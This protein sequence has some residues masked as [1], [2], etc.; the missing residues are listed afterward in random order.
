MART[1]RIKNKRKSGTKRR[2]NYN[3]K[4]ENNYNTKRRT[5]RRTKHKTKRRKN[6]KGGAHGRNEDYLMRLRT[7]DMIGERDF[8]ELMDLAGLKGLS[9]KEFNHQ[10]GIYLRNHAQKKISQYRGGPVFLDYDNIST[11]KQQTEPQQ[12]E[13]QQ[14]TKS[15]RGEATRL[16]C[17]CG[18]KPGKD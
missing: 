16:S 13:P 4:R 15:Q 9:D 11:P 2:N 12:T 18:S 14:Q 8:V 7:N 10:V 3:T 17:F 6:K 1:R 5:K